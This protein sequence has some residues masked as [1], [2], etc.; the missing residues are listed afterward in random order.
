M[1]SVKL[2][3]AANLRRILRE[4]NIKAK[5]LAKLLGVSPSMVT[6]WRNGDKFPYPENIEKIA[7]ALKVK[8]TELFREDTDPHPS[9]HA[10]I[11][12]ALRVI[13]EAHNYELK[14]KVKKT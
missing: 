8:Y 9:G 13:A 10:E 12:S 3:F 14:V 6:H 7:E 11:D 2:I 1:A 4:K 5:E